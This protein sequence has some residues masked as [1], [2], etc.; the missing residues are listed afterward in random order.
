MNDWFVPILSVT[1][2]SIVAVLV[3]LL[4]RRQGK[5]EFYAKTVSAERLAWIKD[6][7]E[8]FT[9]LFTICTLYDEKDMTGEKLVEFEQTRNAILIRLNPT[10]NCY[11]NDNLLRSMLLDRSF[12]EIKVDI[13]KIRETIEKTIKSE[14]DKI[15]IESGRN[16]WLM[17]ENRKSTDE[18]EKSQKKLKNDL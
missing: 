16:K 8:F 17:A 2:S 6:M 5:K 15:K 11:K 18:V 9:K 14:W 13:P 3:S 4:T 7:R 12:S 1:L 10:D